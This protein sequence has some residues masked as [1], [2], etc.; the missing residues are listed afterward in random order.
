MASHAFQE[1][2]FKVLRD[3]VISGHDHAIWR[4]SYKT[5]LEALSKY[6]HRNVVVLVAHSV[7]GATERVYLVYESFFGGS[8]D[9]RIAD[10]ALHRPGRVK[11]GLGLARA[12][13]YLHTADRTSP[14]FQRDVKSAN[15]CL[16]L[17]GNC[18]LLDFGQAKTI[19]HP[20]ANI[21]RRFT[22]TSGARTVG[23]RGY[24]CPSM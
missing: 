23:T 24:M 4:L 16:D 1:V 10:P 8:L 5:E 19:R 18:K 12:L 20:R 17:A 11:I 22:Y 21:G 14:A 7:D 3:E 2:H 6:R 9:R 13:F 15:I